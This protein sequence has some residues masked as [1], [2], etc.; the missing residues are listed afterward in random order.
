ML[1]YEY[2]QS[3]DEYAQFPYK[4]PTYDSSISMHPVQYMD[5]FWDSSYGLHNTQNI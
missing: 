1:I 3:H 5:Q 4:I 2:Q